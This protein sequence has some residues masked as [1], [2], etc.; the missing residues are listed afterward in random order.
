MKQALVKPLIKK[1]S[2]DRNDLKNYRPVSNL[3]FLSKILERLVLLQL[4]AHLS[5][6]NLLSSLQSAYRPAHSTETA[7]LKIVND[8]LMALNNGKVSVLTLLDLSAAFDTIDH[9]IM[10][11]RLEATFGITGS[12]LS[13]F[14]SYLSDRIQ[15]VVVNGISSESTVLQFGVPQGSVLG[16]VLFVLY[17]NPLFNLVKQYPIDHHA[18]ADDNQLYKDSEIDQIDTTVSEMEDCVVAVKA[19]MTANKLQLNDSK[20]ESM[21]VRSKYRSFPENSLPSSI[22]V[23]DSDVNFVSSVTNLGVTFD[24]F[25]NLSQHVQN[26]RTIAYSNL[27]KISSI[28][29]YLTPQAAQTL[30]CS[31]V[32]SRIDYCNSLFYGCDQKLVESLQKVQ[33]SAAKLI[34]RSKKFD[35]VTPLLRS[36]H[37]LPVSARIRYKLACIC[38]SAKFEDGPK[39]LKELLVTYDNPSD[40]NLRSRADSRKLETLERSLPSFGNRSFASAAAIVWNSLPSSVRHSASKDSFRSSLKT[41]LFRESL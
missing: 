23:G 21:L 25:L 41:H 12:A 9:S 20:T 7:L 18:F 24:H 39:Y 40:Y 14:E 15:T 28:R 3:S 1:S 35:H 33:N 34:Y 6:N 38:F 17:M 8:L 29:H 30:A 10:T 36:L 11:A 2:L 16:P 31:L 19:W 37:W 13:W 4:N 22:H 5:S 26:I 32:L 27:R